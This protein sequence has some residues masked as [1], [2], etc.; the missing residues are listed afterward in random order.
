MPTLYTARLTIVVTSAVRDQI[1]TRLGS[2][3]EAG[4]TPAARLL[5]LSVPLSPTGAL[6][7]THY[8]CGWTMK[9]ALAATIQNYVAGLAPAIQA[10]IHIYDVASGSPTPDQV[11][12]A[13]GLRRIG[14]TL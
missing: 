7:A 1:N 2:E 11:L 6:P 8:W 10:Q 14:G 13:E 5:N 4:D 9:P 3:P 12:A